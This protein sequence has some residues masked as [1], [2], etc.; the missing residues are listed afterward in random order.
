LGNVG[1]DSVRG[2]AFRNLDFSVVKDT[3]IK[4]LGEN[5]KLEFR[6]EIFNILNHANYALPNRTVFNG[7]TSNP[8]PGNTSESAPGT[9]GQILSTVGASR[10]IQLALKLSF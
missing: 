4:P 10:Q 9:A 8:V 1:R 5:G 3:G 2:P 7:P 6:A